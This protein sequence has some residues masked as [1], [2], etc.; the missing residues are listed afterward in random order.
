VRERLGATFVQPPR[1]PLHPEKQSS[2]ESAFPAPQIRTSAGDP[3][4]AESMRNK[5]ATPTRAEALEAW[6]EIKK[7]GE[8][9]EPAL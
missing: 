4:R 9:V 3:V 5:S 8:T 6:W 7:G 2:P 1:I